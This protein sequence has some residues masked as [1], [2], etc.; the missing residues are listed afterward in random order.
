MGTHHAR[1]HG[2]QGRA[3]NRID[4]YAFPAEI[5]ANATRIIFTTYAIAENTS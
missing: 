1:L 5:R 3:A 4:H 2:R